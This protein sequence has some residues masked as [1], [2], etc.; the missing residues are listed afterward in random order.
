MRSS[1]ISNEEIVISLL[2]S[3]TIKEAAAAAGVSERTLYGRMSDKDFQVIYR[4]A[5]ADMV[6]KAVININDKLEAAIETI[7]DV[8]QD[9]KLNPATRLQA[10]QTILNN[11]AKFADRLAVDEGSIVKQLDRLI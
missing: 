7:A 3:G 11:A 10:A 2:G 8:M 1:A 9:K 4:A 5:K 6:R